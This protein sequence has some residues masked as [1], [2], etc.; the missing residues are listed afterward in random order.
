M[1]IG[2]MK[3]DS[4]V[5]SLANKAVRIASIAASPE[6]VPLGAVSAPGRSVGAGVVV[7][8]GCGLW[9]NAG[10]VALGCLESESPSHAMRA[11]ATRSRK[12]RETTHPSYPA[13]SRGG[14]E[15]HGLKNLGG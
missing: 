3:V 11:V 4:S 1:C 2:E 13:L 14:N 12:R 8:L 10:G 5:A 6:V 9:T 15:Q 7:L